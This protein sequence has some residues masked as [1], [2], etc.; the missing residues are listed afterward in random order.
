MSGGEVLG[1]ALNKWLKDGEEGII[2][3]REV[4]QVVWPRVC[5]GR[6]PAHS[7]WATSCE[8]KVELAAEVESSILVGYEYGRLPRG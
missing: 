3:A 6:S 2:V 7:A 8:T 5:E 1:T 4:V